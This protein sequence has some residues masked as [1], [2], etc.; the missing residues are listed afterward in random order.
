[1]SERMTK[2]QV[3]ALKD[4]V[5]TGCYRNFT[6]DEGKVLIDE[7]EACWE[8]IKRLEAEAAAR[9]EAIEKL[10]HRQP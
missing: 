9:K 10:L 4:E 6:Y 1:M 5:V 3:K 7:V 8:D 2:T